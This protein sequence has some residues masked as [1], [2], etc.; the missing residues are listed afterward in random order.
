MLKFIEFRFSKLL[1]WLISEFWLQLNAIWQPQDLGSSIGIRLKITLPNTI[2]LLKSVWP[3]IH[4][5]SKWEWFIMV[6][7]R[8]GGRIK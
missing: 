5:L 2:S 4:Y 3:D 6:Y 7:D 8:Q 1:S